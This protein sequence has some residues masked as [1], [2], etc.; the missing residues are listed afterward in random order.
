MDGQFSELLTRKGKLSNSSIRVALNSFNTIKERFCRENCPW[1]LMEVWE[2]SKLQISG[3]MMSYRK[4]GHS[5]APTLIIL[6]IIKE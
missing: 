3:K 4:L 1:D 6:Q 2:T 5:Q